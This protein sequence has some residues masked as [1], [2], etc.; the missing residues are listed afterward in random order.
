MT[1]TE[2]AETTELGP[3]ER[4]IVAGD[5]ASLSERERVQL[6]LRTC[7]S[8][9]LNPFTRPFDYLRLSGRLVL[10]ATRGCADQLRT[11]RGVSVTAVRT[12]LQGDLVLVTVSA[13]DR[14]GR[15]D[16]DVGAVHVA[17]LRGEALANAT[18]KAVTKAK[19]R[20][21]L[22]LCGL[23]WID[24][25]E[26]DSIPGAERLSLPA[27]LP[28]DGGERDEPNGQAPA[29]PADPLVLETPLCEE[30]GERLA[31][32]TDS[33]GTVRTV[34]QIAGRGRRLLGRV[35]C[36]EHLRAAERERQERGA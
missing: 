20:V 5:L 36:A 4:A 27:S 18:M 22:S 13:R 29:P 12:E 16:S 35:L 10:Y 6:Y 21:T 23:G 24:E 2:M 28:A 30:C 15:E 9:G 26:V 7:E 31:D 33:R 14:S 17:G 32:A 8:L 1:D 34:V 3:L 25:S 19:R 11:R